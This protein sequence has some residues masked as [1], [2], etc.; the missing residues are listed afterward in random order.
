MVDY[1]EYAVTL[2]D[3]PELN[4]MLDTVS[5][6]EYPNLNPR[7]INVFSFRGRSRSAVRKSK[8][9]SQKRDAQYVHVE[10]Q[11]SNPRWLELKP[12]KK[13]LWLKFYMMFRDE[14]ETKYVCWLNQGAFVVYYRQHTRQYYAFFYAR[15]THK[16]DIDL[17]N[18]QQM[19]SPIFVGNSFGQAM[20]ELCRWKGFHSHGSL[21]DLY[22]KIHWKNEKPPRNNTHTLTHSQGFFYWH[23][24]D[25]NGTAEHGFTI[26]AIDIPAINPESAIAEIQRRLAKHQTQKPENIKPSR[27]R[28]KK[29]SGWTDVE[30]I[31]GYQNPKVVNPAHMVEQKDVFWETYVENL[32]NEADG[33]IF[34]VN[35]KDNNRI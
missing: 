28:I 24:K 22:P 26:P 3:F 19:R 23:T 5:T 30:V 34:I 32:R 11:K 10:E 12:N 8:R 21:F 14:R 2:R 6:W 17:N 20:M 33:R 7:Y 1:G 13:T 35:D 4:R 15:M 31:Q 9:K 27:H 16:T 18:I 25:W 29:H